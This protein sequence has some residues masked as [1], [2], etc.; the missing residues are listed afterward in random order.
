MKRG[1]VKMTLLVLTKSFLFFYCFYAPNTKPSSLLTPVK[2]QED[3]FSF[4]PQSFMFFLFIIGALAGDS[5]EKMFLFFLIRAL[6]SDS[7]GKKHFF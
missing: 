4:Q 2:G 1:L 7:S 6:T 5:S 3:I